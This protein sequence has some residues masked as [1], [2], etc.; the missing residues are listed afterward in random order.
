LLI[1]VLVEGLLQKCGTT[2]CATA[3]LQSQN[4][5]GHSSSPVVERLPQVTLSDA[6]PGCSSISAQLALLH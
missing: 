2:C 5:A 6:G 1:R 4:Y 3:L